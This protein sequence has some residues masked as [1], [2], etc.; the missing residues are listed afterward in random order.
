[1]NTKKTRSTFFMDGTEA[2]STLTTNLI[3]SFLAM[4]LKGLSPLKALKAFKD[5]KEA[6]LIPLKLVA[7]SPSEA[8]TTKKS[9]TF[10]YDLR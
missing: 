6:I 5:C 7:K 4:T 1:M 3:P 10:Q 9:S 8:D 2:K